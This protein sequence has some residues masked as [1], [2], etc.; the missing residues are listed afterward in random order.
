[1]NRR[2]LV[3]LLALA[4][5]VA[6]PQL[7]RAGTPLMCHANDIGG[8]ASLP[9]GDTSRS[10]HAPVADYPA[11]RLVKD[12]LDLLTARTPVLVRMETMRRATIYARQFE[13]KGQPRLA[14]ELLARLQARALEAEATSSADAPLAWF[15]AGYLAASLAEWSPR[16]RNPS[17]TGYNWVMRA[18]R[19]RG[20]DPEMEFA[21]AL[22]TRQ[23]PGSRDGHWARATAGSKTDPLLARNLA[24]RLTR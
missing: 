22:I 24:A 18:L 4:A 5:T 14:D 16:H 20:G 12:T 23:Q 21:A 9:W 19:A 7:A 2:S 13:E 6:F 15:D 10:H 3:T 8:A 11:D 17:M 1:M